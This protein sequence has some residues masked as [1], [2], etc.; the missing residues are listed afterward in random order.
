V[1]STL[2][3][4]QNC[5]FPNPNRTSNPFSSGQRSAWVTPRTAAKAIQREEPHISPSSQ[6][7]KS[8]SLDNESEFGT[9]PHLRDS[10]KSTLTVTSDGSRKSPMQA[11]DEIDLP[12]MSVKPSSEAGVLPRELTKARL[13]VPHKQSSLTHSDSSLTKEVESSLDPRIHRGNDKASSENRKRSV[14]TLLD[15][16]SSFEMSSWKPLLPQR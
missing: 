11:N 1:T 4:P 12:I 6:G 16:D 2:K 14:G 10:R 8:K 5:Q 7:Q 15:G 9:H 13:P 3:P